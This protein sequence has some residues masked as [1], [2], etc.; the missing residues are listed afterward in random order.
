MGGIDE[1]T[2]IE[3]GPSPACMIGT[4]VISDPIFHRLSR[5][6]AFARL[7]AGLLQRDVAKRM[8]TTTSA[9]SRLENAAGHRPTLAT[10]E[11]Y[12]RAV[13]C[14]LDIRLAGPHDAWY[15]ELSLLAAQHVGEPHEIRHGQYFAAKRGVDTCRKQ[16]RL[17]GESSECVTQ[18]LAPLAERRRD[19]PREQRFIDDVRAIFAQRHQS[20]HR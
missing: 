11:R 8:G 13:G 17:A 18:R 16:L 5:E 7:R 2:G 12:A 1:K 4:R 20:R 9:I 15:R 6:L 19:D 3:R 10:L 14:S